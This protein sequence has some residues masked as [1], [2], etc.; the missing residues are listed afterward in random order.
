MKVFA[1]VISIT[2][3]VLILFQGT[4]A[5]VQAKEKSMRQQRRERSTGGLEG[6]IEYYTSKMDG[7][8]HPYVICVTDETDEPKQT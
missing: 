6:R 8:K 2:Y 7:E 5:Q 3:L 1:G 4:P